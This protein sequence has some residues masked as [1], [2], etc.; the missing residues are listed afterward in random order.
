MLDVVTLRFLGLPKRV[1]G[2]LGADSP[3]CDSANVVSEFAHHRL[4]VQVELH[5][6]QCD[7]GF[8]GQVVRLMMLCAED[9]INVVPRLVKN[10]DC[11]ADHL[12]DR[13]RK[14]LLKREKGLARRLIE[15]AK[16]QIA[17]A[18]HCV[19][20]EGIE[21]VLETAIDC[22]VGDDLDGLESAAHFRRSC[23]IATFKHASEQTMR[24][25]GNLLFVYLQFRT[26]GSR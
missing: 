26:L 9:P 12:I 17:V 15:I 5:R 22:L 25:G 1:D 14:I 16:H 4:N 18:E 19:T 6:P 23:C 2:L 11:L 20:R 21:G 7:D 13:Y 10:M 3:H 24:H 8:V